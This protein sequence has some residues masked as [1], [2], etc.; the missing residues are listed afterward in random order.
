MDDQAGRRP[1]D[2]DAAAPDMGAEPTE[3][4]PAGPGPARPLVDGDDVRSAYQR[5]APVYALL[6][7]PTI[8]GRKG[9]ARRV[10]R[11]SGR[12]LE[13]GVGTGSA[14]PLYGPH[15]RIVGVDLSHD[16]L[17]RARQRIATDRLDH[18]EGVFEMDLEHLAFPDGAF[19]GVVCMFTITA[20]PNPRR[21]MEEFA[22]VT[23]V[24][25]HVVIASHFKAASG[26]WWVTDRLLTPF[27]RRLGWNPA[28][29]I[30]AVLDAP[31]LV[32]RERTLL[33]PAG[34]VTM[35]VFEKGD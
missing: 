31:G 21:V 28:M 19:D 12:I 29:E 27:A 2:P 25:G 5:W 1:V 3:R 32:L 35:L 9:A 14:L 6:A 18:V 26:P 24:G 4:M 11:L 15:L 30:S 23:K 33:P 7:S 20:V 13:A 34:L 10:N 16:M 8:P 22:R 17:V